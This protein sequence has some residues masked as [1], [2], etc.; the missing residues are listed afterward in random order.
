[1]HE[2]SIITNIIEIAEEH[3]RRSKASKIEKIELEIGELAGVEW[4]A[5]DFA[6]EVGVQRSA[7]QNAE[8]QIDKIPGR[9]QCLECNTT[10][11]L[12]ALYNPCPSCGS[13]FNKILQGKELSVKALIVT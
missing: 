4:Q 10:F 9:A 13:Y 1:M 7:L 2:L 11:E 6:W 8:R 3:L 5:L 12:P